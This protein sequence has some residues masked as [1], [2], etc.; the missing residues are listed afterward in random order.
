MKLQ[1]IE[2]AVARLLEALDIDITDPNFSETPQRVA[3]MFKTELELP[4]PKLRIFPSKYDQMIV[5]SGHTTY[6]RCPH[7][8]ERV[9]LTVHV[10]YLPHECVIGL[11]KIARTV[12]HICAGFH[13]QEDITD[14]IVDFLQARLDPLGCGCV[15][16][17]EHLCMQARGV[18]TT[19]TVTTSALRKY[20]L[21]IPD[22]KEEFFNRIGER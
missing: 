6:T 8:L 17:G 7:H 20:F 19:G 22:V 9:K 21:K 14:R 16:K 18:H 11:S 1:N 2:E 10:G 4:E 12:D 3:R 5:L 13:L 15:V